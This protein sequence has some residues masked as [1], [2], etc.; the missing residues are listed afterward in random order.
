M[1]VRELWW[2]ELSDITCHTLFCL[3]IIHPSVS[4]CSSICL[5][6]PPGMSLY[7]IPI[8]IHNECCCFYCVLVW[9]IPKA[10]KI[11]NLPLS[12]WV[13]GSYPA[14]FTLCMKTANYGPRLAERL[15][16]RAGPNAGSLGWIWIVSQM[17]SWINMAIYFQLQLESNCTLLFTL[18]SSSRWVGFFLLLKSGISISDIVVIKQWT[19]NHQKGHICLIFSSVPHCN[20]ERIRCCQITEQHFKRNNNKQVRLK[21]KWWS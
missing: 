8:V 15:G 9:I 7:L 13:S 21:K 10:E 4:L 16:F 6:V 14:C 11:P 19:Q 12:A 17:S 3:S 2:E 5:H 20:M 18:S 1:C